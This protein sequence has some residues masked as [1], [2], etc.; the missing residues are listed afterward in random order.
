MEE[1]RRSATSNTTTNQRW[2]WHC[3]QGGTME[4]SRCGQ[5][6]T[7]TASNGMSTTAKVVDECDSMNGCDEEHADQPPCENNI[8]DGSDA[9][10]EA[11]GLDKGLGNV[12]VTCFRP[13]ESHVAQQSRRD[14]LRVQAISTSVQHLDDVP[15]N[16]EQLSVHSGLNP[17][18]V[19][20]RNV[21]NANMLHDPTTTTVFSSETLNFATSSNGCLPAPRSAMFDE[22][23][24]SSDPQACSNWRSS[25]SQ[26]CY[27]WMANYASGSVGRQ[28]NQKPIFDGDVL[29]N[30]ARVTNI[31][32]PTQYMKPIYNG[33]QSVQSSLANLSSEIPGQD[34]QK[35]H[36]EM[37][38]ASH[39]HPL[40]Q[41]TPVDVVSPASN[42]G[43]N[44]RILLPAAYGNQSTASYFENANAWMNRPV[45]NCHQ[46]SSELGLITRKNGQ[47]LRTLTSDPNT[48]VL[49]LS[50]SSNPPSR[51]NVTQFGEGY[52]SEYLQSK[53][54]VLKEPHHQDSKI[55]N[56]SNYLCTMSKPAVIGRGSGKSFND[57][58][59]TSNYNVLRN[60]G[61]LGP[62][63]GYA[64]ILK[65]SKFLKP[66]QQ[67]LDE[68]CSA[69]GSK[70][71]I[72]CEGSARISG[73]DAET[74]PED[75]NNSFG[76]S[77]SAFYGSNEASGDVGVASSS[78]ESFTPEYQQKKAKLLYLQEEVGYICLISSLG[79]TISA[80]LY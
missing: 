50:L 38:F 61:P 46:W 39:M 23:T 40:Y 33:Y 34:S 52:E 55:F 47:E 56:S 69:T 78:C 4:G 37:Q 41:N 28:N 73:A 64:T 70:L 57:I 75:N 44:E 79:I 1:L 54:G 53:S 15:N 7:I 30:N 77:L 43:G 68:F 58:V 80:F 26:Q 17:D 45:D 71:L 18:I 22:E 49:S 8:V 31:S 42:I 60:A 25:D 24:S 63:T 11:L 21:R 62:F 29:S 74:G 16:L 36:R 72:A 59:G 51:G 14:K 3:P 76:V 67:L 6:I 20:V 12:G 9:V 35:Q 10:W 5:M 48:Q 32:T 13:G 66:A 2:W 65:S 27:D 19:Q